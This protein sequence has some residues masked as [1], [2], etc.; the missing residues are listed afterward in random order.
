MDIKLAARV[1][2]LSK[3]IVIFLLAVVLAGGLAFCLHVWHAARAAVAQGAQAAASA[4]G[5][6]VSVFPLRPAASRFEPVLIASDFRSAVQFA[7]D[8]Y[9]CAGSG[10]FRYSENELKQTWYAGRELPPAPLLS[11]AVRTGVGVPELWIATDGAGILIYNGSVFRQ[12]L[13]EKPALR[14]IS[15]VLPLADGRVLLGTPTAGLYVTDGKSLRVFHPE[16]ANTQVTAL[17]GDE[18]QFWVGTRSDGAWLWRGGE[19]VHIAADLPDPQVLS[20]A[21]NADNAWIG[22]P[23]GVAEFKD[24]KLTRRLADGIFAQALA[25]HSGELVDSHC[26]SR[27]LRYS[28][29]HAKASAAAVVHARR[30]GIRGIV[31]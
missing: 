25:Q 11:V 24:G 22:T 16:F 7:G 14:N 3:R 10:L 12:F 17:A 29:E 28:S 8:L 15:A 30:N 5:A 2:S 27:N 21:S 13:P 26:R 31:P 1:S 23:L 4:G 19:A 18:D 20:L 9:I 6:G